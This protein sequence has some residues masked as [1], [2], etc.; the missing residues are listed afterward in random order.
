MTN[1]LNPTETP[2]PKDNLIERDRWNQMS[3][4]ERYEHE[5][6]SHQQTM[7]SDIDAVKSLADEIARLKGENADLQDDKAALL[8][9]I[10]R[11]ARRITDQQ[12]LI[13]EMVEGLRPFEAAADAYT[14]VMQNFVVTG[15]TS[16]ERRFSEGERE[17]T[18]MEA[19]FDVLHELSFDD[20]H[21]RRTL[22]AK[23]TEPDHAL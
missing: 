20:L 8:A 6:A 23:A 5:A 2:M 3:W 21:R 11:R 1:H 9:D 7:R 18:A 12:A 4:Q 17:E 15:G 19:A 10:D 14:A 13:E 22:I 16:A